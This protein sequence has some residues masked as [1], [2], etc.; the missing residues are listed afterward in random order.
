MREPFGV[1]GTKYISFMV[2]F[3]FRENE[4]KKANFQCL[5]YSQKNL[6]PQ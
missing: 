3:G 5:K 2:Y 1:R 4:V 6:S